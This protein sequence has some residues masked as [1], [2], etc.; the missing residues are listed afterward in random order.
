M[1]RALVVQ[2]DA[3]IFACAIDYRLIRQNGAFR[4]LT[5]KESVNH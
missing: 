5:A 3:Q 1:L 2:T 4:R